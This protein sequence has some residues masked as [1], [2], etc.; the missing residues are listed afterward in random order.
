M[1]KALKALLFGLLALAL[2]VVVACGSTEEPAEETTADED[3]N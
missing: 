1:N 2:F 3:S